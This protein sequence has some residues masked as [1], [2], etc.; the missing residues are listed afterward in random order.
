MEGFFFGTTDIDEWYWNGL[1][2]TIK[3]IDRI[4]ALP[5]IDDLSFYYQSSW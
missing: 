3:Q 5:N 4:L 2:S 1:K